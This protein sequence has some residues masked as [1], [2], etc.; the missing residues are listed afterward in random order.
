MFDCCA[1]A[2]TFDVSRTA[3]LEAENIMRM[4]NKTR[5]MDLVLE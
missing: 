5:F 2:R 1:D 4:E 3:Q